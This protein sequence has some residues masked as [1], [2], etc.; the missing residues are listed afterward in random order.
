MEYLTN[1]TLQDFLSDLS[2]SLSLLLFT[3]G[4]S[5]NPAL[6]SQGPTRSLIGGLTIVL[7]PLYSMNF[8]L[9]VCT[10]EHVYKCTL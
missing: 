2:L 8:A 10:L 3:F 5:F 4:M 6:T 7:S 1:L 9:V